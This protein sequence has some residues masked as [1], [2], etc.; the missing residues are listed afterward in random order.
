MEACR[1]RRLF[2]WKTQAACSGPVSVL[3][4]CEGNDPESSGVIKKVENM[5]AASP[6]N[7][8][9]ASASFQ[10]DIQVAYDRHKGLVLTSSHSSK[11]VHAKVCG[12][13]HPGCVRCRCPVHASKKSC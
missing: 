1:R 10:T 2:T 5:A 12:R 6:P 9:L 13:V 8:S 7:P 4:R 11:A 3:T